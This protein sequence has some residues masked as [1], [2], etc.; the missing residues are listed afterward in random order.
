[1]FNGLLP[2]DKIY[3]ARSAE[4][5]GA[6]RHMLDKNQRVGHAG[7]LDS[8]ASGELITLLGYATRLSDAVMLLPKTYLASVQLGWETSTDDSTG[9]V[10]SEPV[11]V[12]FQESD[13]CAALFGF[14]GRRLQIPPKISAVKVSGK[15]MHKLVRSGN[16]LMPEARLV[17]IISINYLGSGESIGQFRLKIYCHKGT[18]IRSIARDLGRSL[19]TGAHLCALKRLSIGPYELSDAVPFNPQQPPCEKELVNGIRPISTLAEYYCTYQANDFCEQRLENG[20]GVYVE[21][22]A[23]LH[24]G[25][26]PVNLGLAVL[27]PTKLCL[28]TLREETGM[29]IV[30]PK[31]VIPLEVKL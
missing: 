20:L 7:T 18:Y 11:P 16:K 28:C 29:G 21:R 23:F 2:L 10:L 6:V 22:M 3:G 13:I 4:C 14:L 1:M 26:V 30:F 15:P 9:E 5:V 19:G 24:A 12:G 31:T 17:D 25:L 8:T 27:G